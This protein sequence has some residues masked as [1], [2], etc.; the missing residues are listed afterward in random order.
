MSHSESKE[1][2]RE[3]ARSLP[4]L[5]SQGGGGGAGKEVE[6]EGGGGRRLTGIAEE[7]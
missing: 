6:E 3:V 7:G 1:T 2:E 5:S 4:S